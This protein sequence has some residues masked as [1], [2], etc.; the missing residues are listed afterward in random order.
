[1]GSRLIHK[2]TPLRQS[3]CKDLVAWFKQFRA[4]LGRAAKAEFARED[5]ARGPVYAIYDTGGKLIG[6]GWFGADGNPKGMAP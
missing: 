6:Y 1:M 2:M 3:D 5:E 4:N